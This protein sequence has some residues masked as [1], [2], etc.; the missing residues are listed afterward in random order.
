MTCT[1]TPVVTSPITALITAPAVDPTSL[2]LPVPPIESPN[3]H[4]VTPPRREGTPAPGMAGRLGRA[5]RHRNYRLFFIGQSIS[6]M[7]T[8][9]TIFATAWMAYRL[10]H[11]ALILG[12]VGFFGQAPT[13][14]LAP[15]AGVL[16]DRWD[17][18]RTIVVTQVAAMLQS[19]ALA[20]F[21][22]TGT[23]TVWHLLVLVAVQAAIN[24]FDMPAR[25]S[26][27]SQ[28]IDDRADLPNAIALNSSIVNSGRLIGPVIA[29]VLVD[30]FGEGICFTVDAA[31]YFA[32]L[33]SLLM[34]RVKKRPPRARNGRVGAELADGLRYVW[35]LPLVRAVLLLIALSSVLGSS[36]GTL[37]PLVATTTLHGGPHTLGILMG[38]A[39][40]GALTAALY[41]AS[42]STVLG[43]PTVLQRC[44]LS[45]GAGMVALEFATT[46]WIAVPLLFIIG[47]ALMMQIAGTNTLVQTLADDKMLGRVISLYAVALFGGAPVGAL[48]EGMLAHRIGA[49]H[50]IAIAGVLCMAGALVFASALP[51]LR[52][53]SRPLYVRRGLINE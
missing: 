17:R 2:P 33:A 32:V 22:L 11:S 46:M 28:M 20:V 39:G 10:T 52:R 42:R 18:H 50:T 34:M 37:L 45:L 13:S 35:S 9:L 24:G 36:Y 51:R 26:F 27:M 19:T 30:Q 43:L 6:L 8:W 31:S 44:A 38:S 7:G 47:M 4:P 21:A 49:I 23:M 14:L 16:I 41:L 48:L 1:A 25:Q 40:F 15:F 5:L 3:H 29:A 12:L 53:L